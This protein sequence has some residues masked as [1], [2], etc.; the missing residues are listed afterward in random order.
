M[1]PFI[2]LIQVCIIIIFFELNAFPA[3]IVPFLLTYATDLL[4]TTGLTIS[5]LKDLAAK[6][7]H[8]IFYFLHVFAYL[9]S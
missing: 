2:N 1:S 8:F 9:S 5:N 4:D 3:Y 6:V 7:D